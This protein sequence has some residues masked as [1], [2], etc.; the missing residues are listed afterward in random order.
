M[1]P[2]QNLKPVSDPL[3]K[4]MRSQLTTSFILAL[5]NDKFKDSD[6]VEVVVSMEA[7]DLK[8]DIVSSLSL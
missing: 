6:I 5:P 4:T 1:L 3:L 7:M 8:K 2:Q